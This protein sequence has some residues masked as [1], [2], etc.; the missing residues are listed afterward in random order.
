VRFEVEAEAL[1]QDAQLF[2]GLSSFSGTVCD[3]DAGVVDHAALARTTEV[4]H[5]LAQKCAALQARE[6]RV[7]LCVKHARVAQH[8]RRALHRR[9]DARDDDMMRR[10]VV[11][12]LLAR[13]EMVLTRRNFGLL[14][15]LVAPAKRG[16]R[17]VANHDAAVGELLHHAHQVA[18]ALLIQSA[19]SIE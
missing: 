11:L 2:C 1:T 4:L 3:D 9:F 15:D 16:Q 8:Q 18:L 6:T 12:H 14:S 19:H 10:C 13:L 5:C 17:G 7:D